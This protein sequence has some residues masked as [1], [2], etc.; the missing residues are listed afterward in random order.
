MKPTYV[1]TWDAM[2]Q[3]ADTYKDK[4]EI[5]DMVTG[6]DISLETARRSVDIYQWEPENTEDSDSEKKVKQDAI[7]K[8][9]EMAK[10]M[11]P[12]PFANVEQKKAVVEYGQDHPDMSPE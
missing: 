10:T 4:K 8:I 5:R 12:E 7:P 3:T 2:K 6:G 1:S 9:I 11:E